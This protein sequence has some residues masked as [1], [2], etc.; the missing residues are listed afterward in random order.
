LIRQTLAPEASQA[1]CTLLFEHGDPRW[2]EHI[3][4][5]SEPVPFSELQAPRPIWFRKDETERPRGM[6]Y[7]SPSRREGRAQVRLALLFNPSESAAMAAGTLY[8]AW[9]E[10]IE[11][12]DD[13]I[14]TEDVLR[15]VAQKLRA[16]LPQTTW[17]KLNELLTNFRTWLRNPAIT[18][19]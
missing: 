10:T 18:S 5:P 17:D 6:K 1:E 14:P 7:D 11:W 4:A 3:E 9:F 2:F 13:G 16:E 12:I 15:T 8:H 19:V